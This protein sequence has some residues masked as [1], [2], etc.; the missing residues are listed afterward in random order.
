MFSD[1]IIGK[2]RGG[3]EVAGME[4]VSM[5]SRLEER[6]HNLDGF[7]ACLLALLCFLVGYGGKGIGDGM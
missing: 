2:L 7:V 1:D 5:F 4:G 3:M 6:E